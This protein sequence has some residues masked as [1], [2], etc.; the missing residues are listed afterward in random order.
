MTVMEIAKEIT[1]SHQANA[2]MV[3]IR[4]SKHAAQILGVDTTQ[5]FADTELTDT[6]AAQLRT[7]LAAEFG[8][9]VTRIGR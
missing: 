9:T 7:A 1:A 2:M 5:V 8:A 4:S 3:A 6:Q